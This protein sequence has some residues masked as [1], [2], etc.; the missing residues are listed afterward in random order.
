MLKS[1]LA[2]TLVCLLPIAA[3]G[4]EELARQAAVV[5]PFVNDSTALVARLDLSV[6]VGQAAAVF[7]KPWVTAEQ[8]AQ[9]GQRFK[10]L[11]QPFAALGVKEAFLLS[12][13]LDMWSP[14]APTA[15]F[16]VVVPVADQANAAAVQRLLHGLAGNAAEV[17]GNVVLTGSQVV[18]DRLKKASP[19]ARPD[20]DAAWQATGGGQLQIAL[21]PPPGFTK[22]AGETLTEPD[23]KLGFAPGPAVAR[24]VKWAA[25]G[26]ELPPQPLA[27]RFVIQSSDEQAAQQLEKLFARGL[28][29]AEASDGFIRQFPSFLGRAKVALPKRTGSQLVTRIDE[30]HVKP[31]SFLE[32]FQVPTTL[33]REKSAHVVS[34]TNLKQ[35]ALA[36]HVY[37]DAHQAL[38][39]RASLSK[40]GKPLLSWRVAILPYIEQGKLYQEFHLDEPWDSEH[41][42]K[43]IAKIPDVFKPATDQKVEPGKTCYLVPVGPGTIFE[44]TTGT[45]FADIKDG[46]SNTIM[47]VEAAPDRAVEWTRPDDWT[48]DPANPVQGLIGLRQNAF[49]T[50]FGDGSVLTLTLARLGSLANQ[51]RYF[52][53]ADGEPIEGR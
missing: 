5:A 13:P 23:P 15:A 33:A 11:R 32:L 50:A 12:S 7:G 46:T 10:E 17:R 51:R 9:I 41:N 22:I 14:A 37:H 38:P 3:R 40:E 42:K 44:K 20:F 4:Q 45:H 48:F 28:E 43:L 52:Q 34:V 47:I 16:F 29:K 27:G 19:S 8:S 49:L 36:M 25:L 30:Q 6:D 31:E 21:V 18:L 35:L 39:A 2:L 1:L 53:M 24:G 26:L